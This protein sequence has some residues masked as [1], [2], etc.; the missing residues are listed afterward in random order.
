MTDTNYME[1]RVI[2]KC[3][4]GDYVGEEGTLN[5]RRDWAKRFDSEVEAREYA[6]TNRIY[7]DFKVETA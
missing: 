7:S 4:S 2:L 5:S 6:K 3:H 1:K